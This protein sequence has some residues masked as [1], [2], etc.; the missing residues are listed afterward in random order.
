MTQARIWTA[1]VAVY[2][3]WGSTYLA[4]RIAVASMPPLLMAGTRFL[5]AGAVLYGWRMAV[6]PRS[7]ARPTLVQWRSA[8]IIGAL[9]MLGGNGGVA[10][11]ELTVPSGITAIIAASVPLW[12]AA[13]D[14]IVLGRRLAPAAIAGLTVGFGGVAALVIG[15]GG[16]GMPTAGTLILC[17]AS[18]SW[19]AGSLYVRDADL[20]A[21]SLL[22]VGMEMLAGGALLCV[23]AALT[24]EFAGRS[25]LGATASAWWAFA[26][27]IVFGGIIGFGAYLWLLRVAP[28]T[29]VSTYAYVNP[30]VAVILGASILHETVNAWVVIAGTVILASVALII[31]ARR[32]AQPDHL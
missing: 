24:G 15:H 9:L 13:L 4:I 29:V 18:L 26:Y 2:I 10:L 31:T 30:V 7:A 5:I 6:T 23:A 19:A 32:P 20:P 14:R 25:M 8:A 17:A 1:L 3:L 21:D 16:L 28:T 22:A 11:G 12:L 27:L